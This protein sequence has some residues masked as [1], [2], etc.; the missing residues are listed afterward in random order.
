[1]DTIYALSSGIVPCGVAVIRISGSRA[2]EI[3]TSICGRLPPPRRARLATLRG[4]A[5]HIL[6]RGLVLWFPAPASVTGEDVA[7]FQVHGS[8]AVVRALFSEFAERGLRPAE[9]GEYARR[10]FV[11]HK[12][13]LAAAEGLADLI[14]AET[15]MQR[16]QALSQLDGDLSAKLG[17]WREEILRLRAETEARLDFVD[18]GD[19]GEVEDP[20]LESRIRSLCVELRAMVERTSGERIR[21]GIR[22]V[23]LGVPNAGK[24]SLLNRLA[25]RDVAITTPEA[26]TTRDVLEVKLDVAGFPVV[27]SDTAGLRE[28][29]SLA[30][31]SGVERAIRAGRDADLVL[32]A[33]DPLMPAPPEIDVVNKPVWKL[34]SKC[35]LGRAAG[36]DLYVSAVTGEG[37]AEL[38]RRLAEFAEERYGGEEPTLTRSR[39]RTALIQAL[40]LLDESLSVRDELRAELLRGASDEIGR[41]TGT[42]GVEEVLDRVFSEFC[43]G[44]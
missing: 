32:L 24:S 43:I 13:D 16:R 4:S 15:E 35:D 41:I 42:I 36:C 26:G 29:D 27:L 12:L 6:D 18:E 2:G 33:I 3:V 25:A 9:P 1:M 14:A 7:E 21:D 19:V 37:V 22:V 17:T 8:R 39:H 23:I 11:N 10:A 34:G 20:R 5:G 28:S 31:R 30:E 40:A 44:K 38:E